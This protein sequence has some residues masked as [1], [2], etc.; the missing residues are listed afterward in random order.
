MAI[1]V[2]IN[3][4]FNIDGTTYTASMALPTA[5]PTAT[6]PFLFQ[7][8]SNPTATPASTTA[9]LTVAVG[10]KDQIYVAVA[11]PTSLIAAAAGDIVSALDVQVSEGNYNTT[12]KQFTT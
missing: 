8:V 7:V 5:T 1:D 3:A 4:V 2:Q 11:P 6:A 10:A 12:T 9:L